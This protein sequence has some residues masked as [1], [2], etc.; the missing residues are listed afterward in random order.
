MAV[1][2]QAVLELVKMHRGEGRSVGEV[3]GSVSGA[4]ELLPVEEGRGRKKG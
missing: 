3:L 4:I 1:Q 2:K